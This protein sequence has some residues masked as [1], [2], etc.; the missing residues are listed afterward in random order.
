MARPRKQGIDYFP[1]DTSFLMD[2]DIR[3]IRS[4]FGNDGP[5]VYLYIISKAYE[6]NGY[7]IDDTVDLN[8]FIAS[9]LQIEPKKV[10]EIIDKLIARGL[11]ALRDYGP[12]DHRKTCLTSVGIQK[13]YAQACYRKIKA[14]AV[15]DDIWMINQDNAG[16][17]QEFCSDNA[18]VL[19]DSDAVNNSK[20]KKSKSISKVN[21]SS[22]SCSFITADDMEVLVF[23]YG[24][25]VVDAAIKKMVESTNNPNVSYLKTMLKNGVRDGKIRKYDADDLI[26][27]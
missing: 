9:D 4:K 18:G 17:L 3:A 8:S 12:S 21:N 25:E 23:E 20:E 27:G 14:G 16:V 5:M 13:R 19:Q 6:T 2:M 10:E 24:Q 22:N 1:L 11:L 7:Y 26:G 15:I